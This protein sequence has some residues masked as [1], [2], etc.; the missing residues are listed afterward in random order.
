MKKISAHRFLFAL[1]FIAFA[2]CAKEVKVPVNKANINTAALNT[3]TTTQPSA[4]ATHNCGGGGDHT[5]NSGGG[6]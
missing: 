1:C 5:S 2:G 3:Y 6:Y 4:P